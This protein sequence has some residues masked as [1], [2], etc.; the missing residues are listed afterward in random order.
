MTPTQPETPRPTATPAATRPLPAGELDRVE[1]DAVPDEPERPD[2]VDEAS[3][4]SFPASDPPSRWAGKDEPP[5]KL[6][7]D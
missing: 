7:G 2:R 5:P 6:N 3:E 4:D 1:G